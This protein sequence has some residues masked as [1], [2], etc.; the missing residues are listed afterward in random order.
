MPLSN[1]SRPPNLIFIAPSP[2]R[3]DVVACRESGRDLSSVWQEQRPLGE[4]S[5]L[6]ARLGEVL[7]QHALPAQ[8]RAVLIVPPGVGG[9]LTLPA[10]DD[11]C[12]D[13]AWCRR[14]LELA[15]P[16]PLAEIRYGVHCGNG[17]AR[18]FWLPAAWLDQ[19]KQQL[20]KLGLKLEEIYP[21]AALFEI[22]RVSPGFEG[23]LCEPAEQGELV[24]AFSD[25]RVRQAVQLP[26]GL[27]ATA[28]QVCLAGLREG[29]ASA[30]EMAVQ[31]PAW[32]DS[33]PA[34]WQD[35]GLAITMDAG[36]AALWSPF[37]RLAMLVAIA[38]TVL[39]GAL[40][41]AI[42]DKETAMSQAVREKKKLAAPAQRFQE[43]D[44]NLR[45]QSAV[46]AAMKQ[47]DSAQTPLPMLAKFTQ[48]L[49]K[50]AWVQQMTYDGNS[51]TVAGKGIGDDELIGLLQDAQ[52]EAE[53]TRPEPV[54]DSN[55]FRL[56]VREKPAETPATD[57][58]GAS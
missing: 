45:E 12:R 16:F 48:A 13:A 58:G 26:P 7:R 4:Q 32:A 43:L 28:R 31:P 20:Q 2:G 52:L 54:P 40:S 25:G 17:L 46:V 18:F 57:K 56:R 3:L 47:I 30:Q 53:K 22:G 19:Q 39:A 14:Q 51:I 42:A 27:D 35:T 9:L 21:R 41:W 44:R 15:V 8:T 24:Y 11:I 37:F 23:A 33:L 29:G 34:L 49:P 55:D 1:P 10:L 50:K 36:P 6:A 38:L 5:A